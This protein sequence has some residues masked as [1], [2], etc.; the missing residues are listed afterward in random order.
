MDDRRTL[1]VRALSLSA[2]VARAD[3]AAED[4]L[5]DAFDTLEEAAEA[6]AYLAGFLLEV[7]AGQRREDVDRTRAHLLTLLDRT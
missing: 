3:A 5:V 1:A 7:L 4:L 6:H 2:G